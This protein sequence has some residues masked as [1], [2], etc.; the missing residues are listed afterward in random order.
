SCSPP[1]HSVPLSLSFEASSS[2]G[3]T[4]FGETRRDASTP[5]SWLA[6]SPRWFLLDLDVTQVERDRGDLLPRAGDV[7]EADRDGLI[8]ERPHERAPA[9]GERREPSLLEPARRATD[10]ESGDAMI[11]GS[12]ERAQ[13]RVAEILDVLEREE[14]AANLTGEIRL[15]AGE[16]IE[17]G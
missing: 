15:L 16:L 7:G 12:R 5:S 6:S 8:E 4:R 1:P 3:A 17:K 10:R 11:D 13:L 14:L 2:R 9:I